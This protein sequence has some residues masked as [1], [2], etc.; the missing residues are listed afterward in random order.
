LIT[1]PDHPKS[2]ILLTAS[3]DEEVE[4]GDE[5]TRLAR[6]MTLKEDKANGEEGLQIEKGEL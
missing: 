5:I 3:V 2:K 4:F 6:N 1:N